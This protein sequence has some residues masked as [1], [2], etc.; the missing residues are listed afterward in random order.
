MMKYKFDNDMYYSLRDLLVHRDKFS[1]KDF[2]FCMSSISYNMA[3]E[4]I[5]FEEKDVGI[6]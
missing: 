4:L 2:V 5:D 3:S 1:E 6:A